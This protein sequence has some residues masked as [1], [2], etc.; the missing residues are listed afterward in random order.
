[1][2]RRFPRSA[3][4]LLALSVALA[5]FTLPATSALASEP[6][7]VV[8][9][10]SPIPAS[11]TIVNQTIT[12]SFDVV[13]RQPH[14]AAMSAFIASLSNTASPN[15]HRYV[16]PAQ[17]AQ[18]FGASSSEVAAVRSYLSGYGLHVGTL[19]KGHVL[20]HVSGLT[21]EISHAFNA[22]VA[23]V[24]RSDGMLAA[25]FQ[26]TATLPASMAGDVAS[27]TGLSS[28]VPPSTTSLLSHALSNVATAG[29]CP[30][31]ANGASASS[32]TANS[33][34]GYTLQQQAQLYGFSGAWAS[35]NTGVG[36]TIGVYELGSYNPSDL[37][38]YD[39]CYQIS[40]TVTAI[41]V[42]GGATGGFSD[43][44]TMDVEE[45]SAL[46]P[47][48]TV[49]VYTGPNTAA[50]PTDVYQQMADDNTATVITTPPVASAANRPSSSRWPPRARP[51]LRRRATTVRRTVTAS[52]RTV[53]PST[54][55]HR[56][57]T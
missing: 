7:V 29:S 54:I 9:G 24:R 37:A 43:E 33:L 31:A 11:D 46:A 51:S 47:G 53:R 20:L 57:P 4:P 16:T 6:R 28:V 40:P 18:Q 12:A 30:A 44:A 1:M 3:W 5:A 10:T 15:Y 56:S 19:S 35:G 2:P 34:G 22:P 41:N 38:T 55:R 39:N 27:V 13:L 42:D 50:G 23:T 36:Q 8:A 48:A 49:E 21:S 25:Q 17:F 52:P 32:T 26:T 45:A 14:Q